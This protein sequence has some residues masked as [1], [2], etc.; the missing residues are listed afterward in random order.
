MTVAKMI[1]GPARV[2]FDFRL[3]VAK[4]EQRVAARCRLFRAAEIGVCSASN[5]LR[6]FSS[7]LSS[8]FT[9]GSCRGLM[10][11]TPPC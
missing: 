6:G 9:R 2:W 5:S 4:P 8:A 1:I 11:A 10:A 3:P 7:F